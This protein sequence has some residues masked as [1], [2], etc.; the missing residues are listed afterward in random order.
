MLGDLLE[1]HMRHSVSTRRDALKSGITLGSA[2][3]SNTAAAAHATDTA[4][5]S[6]CRAAPAMKYL[7]QI[8][9]RVAAPVDAGLA[10]GVAKRM[11]PI[12]GGRVSGP[13]FS[14]EG[15]SRGA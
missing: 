14:G 8:E 1:G 5:P 3:L 6:S 4:E 7:C 12:V 2:V 9:A 11:I 13:V 15:L 10:G